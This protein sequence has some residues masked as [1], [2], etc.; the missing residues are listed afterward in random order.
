MPSRVANS[1]PR[2]RPEPLA[3]VGHTTAP[4][5]YNDGPIHDS[6]PSLL[7]VLNLKPGDNVLWIGSGSMMEI[8]AFALR[9]GIQDVRILA[10]ESNREAFDEGL[11]LL[12]V[13]GAR[14]AHGSEDLVLGDWH[15]SSEHGDAM[16]VRSA[17]RCSVVY[18]CAA[19]PSLGEHLCSLAWN[20]NARTCLISRTWPRSAYTIVR[21]R[22]E[23]TVR[24][25]GGL[26][27]TLLSG[28][29]FQ[30]NER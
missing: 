8:A 30:P 7:H 28:Y 11:A 2:H 10:I 17:R 4:V 29:T 18:S 6:L 13:L 3:Q 27:L 15:I 23:G 26:D 20:A 5:R 1:A 22:R 12:D 21:E 24:M 19:A 25:L 14:R 9:S 16:K